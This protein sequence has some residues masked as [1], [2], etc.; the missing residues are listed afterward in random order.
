[1]FDYTLEFYHKQSNNN[2]LECDE[3]A[4]CSEAFELSIVNYMVTVCELLQSISILYLRKEDIF[5]ITEKVAESV[6]S[7]DCNKHRET[8][9]D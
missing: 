9:N 1:M 5:S 3:G 2:C 8:H 7:R 6:L 4:E